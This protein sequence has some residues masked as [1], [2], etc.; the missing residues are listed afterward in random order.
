LGYLAIFTPGILFKFAV[1]PSYARFRT[2]AVIRSALR[3]LNAAAVGLIYVAVYRLFKVGALTNGTGTK[4]L[5]SA[6]YWIVVAAAAFMASN[7]F[8][9][10]PWIVI[11]CGALLGLFFGLAAGAP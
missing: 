11:I 4:S 5:Q 2:I 6:D 8:G 9:V 7:S 3:G 10:Q 1:L